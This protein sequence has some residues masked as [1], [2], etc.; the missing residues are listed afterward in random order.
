MNFVDWSLPYFLA[1][2]SYEVSSV[3]SFFEKLNHVTMSSVSP[4]I[5][6]DMCDPTP[7]ASFTNMV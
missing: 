5:L 7:G 3:V 2:V 6:F 4:P 1:Q